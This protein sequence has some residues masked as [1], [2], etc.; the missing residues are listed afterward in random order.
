M[1]TQLSDKWVLSGYLAEDYHPHST[2]VLQLGLYGVTRCSNEA[3]RNMESSDGDGDLGIVIS[4]QNYV[5]AQYIY[6]NGPVRSPQ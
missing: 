4:H 2:C 3:K 1:R 6:P 5:I